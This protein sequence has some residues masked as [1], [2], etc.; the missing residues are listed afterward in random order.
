MNSH[1]EISKVAYE[2][3]EK[4]GRTDG[5]DMENWIEAERIVVARNLLQERTVKEKKSAGN[6][7]GK[8][9]PASKV[10]NKKV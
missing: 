10:K 9:A 2:L 3:Y 4:N 5:R 6:G 8:K 1:E 7:N